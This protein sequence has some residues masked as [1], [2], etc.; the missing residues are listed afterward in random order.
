MNS[1]ET[2]NKYINHLE[3][4][5][6]LLEEEITEALIKKNFYE[7]FYQKIL[8]AIGS[9]VLISTRNGKIKNINQYLRMS[10]GLGDEII[11]K[12]IFDLIDFDDKKS[13]LIESE[14]HESFLK[15]NFEGILSS[16]NGE[17]IPVSV[18]VNKIKLNEFDRDYFFSIK[19]LSLLKG[20]QDKIVK[21][22]NEIIKNAFRDGVAE[23]AI[24][25]LHNVGNILSG[26]MGKVSNHKAMSKFHNSNKIMKKLF[27][28]FVNSN[29]PSKDT[30]FSGKTKEF[31]TL[32]GLLSDNYE[33][34]ER[35]IIEGASYI[36]DKCMEIG[37]IISNQQKYANFRKTEKEKFNLSE[38][39]KS[40]VFM[41][42]EKF[43]NHIISVDLNIPVNSN[44]K[45]ERIGLIQSLNNLILN[46]IE[47]I[48]EK[49]QKD[50]VFT[51]RQI[52]INLIED[53]S[54]NSYKIIIRDNGIGFDIEPL[55]K[56]FQFGFSTKDRGSGFG[57]YNCKKFFDRSGGEMR[58][59]NNEDGNGASVII[60]L[61]KGF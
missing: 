17:E 50:P 8:D 53:P 36:K 23:N 47:S 4:K 24:C 56:I 39:I 1:E 42:K 29:A 10:F 20:K 41:Y 46:S 43:E 48:D 34:T 28:T 58:V 11:G 14:N 25:V 38:T 32:I 22:Q 16:S 3:R 12:S 35:D 55:N 44:I 9:N 18:V 49:S 13:F 30:H 57:L 5:I 40:C 27:E 6:S 15:K 31:E 33:Q 26:M 45:I 7:E 60:I 51:Q 19:D 37:L 54:K 21:L 2:K 61:P 52:K 59:R